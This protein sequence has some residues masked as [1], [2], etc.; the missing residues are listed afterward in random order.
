MDSTVHQSRSGRRDN[1]QERDRADYRPDIQE[2]TQVWSSVWHC[3]QST[4]MGLTPPSSRTVRAG[5]GA[6]V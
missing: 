4:Q 1:C 5:V 3:G 2:D 6:A